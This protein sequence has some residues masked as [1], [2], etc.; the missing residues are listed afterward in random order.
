MQ[1]GRQARE[2]AVAST[3]LEKGDACE[4]PACNEKIRSV[5]TSAAHQLIARQVATTAV[6]LL[7]G[8]GDFLPLRGPLKI[9]VMGSA[10][11]Y[12]MPAGAL[13][14]GYF[15]GGGSGHVVGHKYVTAIMGIER[16]AATLDGVQVYTPPKSKNARLMNLR[17]ARPG[18]GGPSS[19]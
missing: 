18:A 6:T 1:E 3:I 5:Q 15:A 13:G 9:A 19:T 12:D 10:S 7:K 11:F 16:L 2:A 4:P 8:T 14:A 17:A